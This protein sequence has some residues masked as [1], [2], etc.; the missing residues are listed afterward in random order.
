[1]H[2][3][4]ITAVMLV[5]ITSMVLFPWPMYVRFYLSRGDLEAALKNRTQVP[6]Q[7]NKVIGLYH[8][9]EI[10]AGADGCM[11][12]KVG[13][14]IYKDKGFWK[15]PKGTPVPNGHSFAT[16]KLTDEWYAGGK[17]YP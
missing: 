13:G 17:W 1:M 11:F 6:S 2:R 9:E 12:I 8:V 16:Y 7:V 14:S 10:V 3:W 15:I 5:I 4:I